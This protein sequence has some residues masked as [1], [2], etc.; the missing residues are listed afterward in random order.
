MNSLCRL[1]E[2]FNLH[3]TQVQEEYFQWLRFASISADVQYAKDMRACALWVRDYL[4]KYTQ[5]TSCLIETTGQPIVFA[6][7]LRAGPAAPTVLIYGH[8]D[9][10]PVDPL[11]LWTSPPFEPTMRDGKVYA[12]GALDDK[13]QIFYAVVA[14]RALHEL[15]GPLSVNVKLCIEGEEES[16]SQGLEMALS[17]LKGTLQADAILVVDFGQFDEVTPAI[18]LGARGL[19]ALEVTLTGSNSDLH[20]G[21]HGGLAYNPNR[22]MVELLAKLWG[23]QG[24]IQVDGF[25]DDV[26]EASA[27]LRQQIDFALEPKSYQKTFGVGALGGERGRTMAENNF[28]RPTLEINGIGGG[29]FGAGVKTVIPAHCTAKISCRLVPNQ[30][31]KKIEQKLIEFLKSHVVAGMQIAFHSFGGAPA[32]RGSSDSF[33]AKAIAKAAEEV[34]G[35]AC[36]KVL[37]G[38]S[39]PIIA[40]L[41]KELEAD[42]VGMGY[43]LATDNIHAPNEHFDMSRFEKGFLTLGR[44]IELL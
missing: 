17:Q 21:E 43:G 1:K 40:K 31:P 42:V 33:L 35:R 6:E 3:C 5:M 23:S 41:A 11:E 37:C 27:D 19:V 22:A 24:Y 25:Y 44:A 4:A 26:V 39:I 20:S 29:Y 14:M 15:I 2:W 10:Q 16:A 38:A 34:N 9:V 30:D 12:R 13:G 18:T 7:D 32:F 8:Y 36:K 28:F